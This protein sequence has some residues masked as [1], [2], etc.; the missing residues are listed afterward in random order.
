MMELASL[1]A[2]QVVTL[3][4]ISLVA[5]I[6]RGF[7]GFALSAVVMAAALPL[8][9]PAAL[10]PIC[11]MM[12][13]AAS[14]LLVRGGMADADRRLVLTLLGGTLVGTPLGLWLTTTLDVELAKAVALGALVVFAVMQLLGLRLIFLA[15]A[16]G[17]TVAGLLAGLVTGLANLGGMVVALVVLALRHP[18]REM[19]GSLVLFLVG[20][21]A[22]TFGWLLAYGLLD[23]I[24]LAR[25]ALLVPA[26][27]VGVLIGR[28]G[29]RPSMERWYRPACL[30]LL[31]GLSLIGLARL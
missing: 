10:I 6:V 4:A 17:L 7:S 5:G 1:D 26:A 23:A 13:V 27:M 29:F 28:A 14:A 8:L 22:L 3:L 2:R 19:R 15:T 21:Q 31:V 20:S 11:W 9:P 18:A 25:G 30:T 16:A 24:S 12:E